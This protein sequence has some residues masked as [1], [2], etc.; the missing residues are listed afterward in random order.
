M[1]RLFAGAVAVPEGV[2]AGGLARGE[3][4]VARAVERCVLV[5]TVSVV[6]SNGARRVTYSWE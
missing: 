1:R 2:H 3:L 6:Q 4:L 5:K